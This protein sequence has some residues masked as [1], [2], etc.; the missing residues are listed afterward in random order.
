LE[1]ICENFGEVCTYNNGDTTMDVTAHI[2]GPSYLGITNGPHDINTDLDFT[3]WIS[4]ALKDTN[5]VA[6]R[7]CMAVT[8][9]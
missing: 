7:K 5:G 3:S 1:S 4:G 6:V 2:G 8:K 9:T